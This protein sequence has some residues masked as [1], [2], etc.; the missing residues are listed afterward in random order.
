MFWCRICLGEG[1]DTGLEQDLGFGQVCRFFGQIGVS[2]TG[3]GGGE[4]SELTSREIDGEGKLVLAST[5][6]GLG[7][8]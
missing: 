7:L 8:A 2:D 6:D 4:V 1:G 5:D 3:F